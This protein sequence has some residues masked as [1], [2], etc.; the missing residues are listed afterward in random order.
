MRGHRDVGGQVEHKISLQRLVLRK[1]AGHIADRWNRRS[2]SNGLKL[3][4]LLVYQQHRL[5]RTQ[6]EPF[7]RYR[8]R[9]ADL[10]VQFRSISYA[11]LRHG[12]HAPG[13]D[14]IFLQSNYTPSAGELET[15]LDR[16]RRANPDA[17]ISYFDWF[18]PTDV[19]M[20]ERVDPFVDNYVKKSLL[21]DR[22]AYLAGT[23]GHTNLSDYYALH[24]GTENP[25]ATWAVPPSI[26]PKLVV[27]PAFST[28]ADLIGAFEAPLPNRTRNRTIDVHAR[29][30][31]NG[32]PWYTFMRSQAAEAASA[33]TDL[34]VAH[35]G[36][37]ARK[38]YLKELAQSKV[39]FS[40]FG[41]GE[42]CWRDFEAIANGAVLVKPDM[43]HIDADPDIYIPDVT[44]IPVKWDFSDLEQRI[45]GILADGRR[46]HQIADNAFTVL[47]DHLRDG[48]IEKLL[49]RLSERSPQ[50]SG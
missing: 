42:I 40:P 20:A 12:A 27:G 19:R 38:Q 9:F 6:F 41:Y 25:P 24:F 50:M 37:V 43:G 32:T 26:L 16:L 45:R 10:G 36:I 13:A 22:T 18:A 34:N 30:A 46:R 21:K 44:Y 3:R 1:T 4:V 28:G 11:A 5:A 23:R 29:I 35:A 14:C 47:H 39:V 7:H 8:S 49:F 31:Q 33:L 17:S 2:F 15:V 48:S